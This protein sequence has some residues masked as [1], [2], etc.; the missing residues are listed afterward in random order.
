MFEKYIVPAV[1]VAAFVIGGLL[2]QDKGKEIAMQL[3]D[4]FSELSSNSDVS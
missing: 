4:K 1:G 2:A 3:K